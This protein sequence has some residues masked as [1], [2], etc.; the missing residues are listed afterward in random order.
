MD[1]GLT[2]HPPARCPGCGYKLDACTP[3]P[4]TPAVP[5]GPGDV[6]ICARCGQ[7]LVFGTGMTPRLPLPGE[8]TPG[9]AARADQIQARLRDIRRKHPI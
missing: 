6:T 3:A 9:G 7:I 8:L 5:P 4:G 1:D 2:L